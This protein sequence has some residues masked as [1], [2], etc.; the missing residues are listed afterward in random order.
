MEKEMEALK[1]MV[2][3]YNGKWLNGTEIELA[4]FGEP[5]V[6]VLV[7]QADGV[8]VVLGTHDHNYE[9]PD[10]QI[11]RRH[12]GWMIFLHPLGG[13]DASGH[14]VF[15]DDG[16]SF[17][18]KENGIGPTEPIDMVEHGEA[19]AEVDD[20]LP[21]G[22]SCVPS[23]VV[24]K[25]PVGRDED[26]QQR[27]LITGPPFPPLA[28]EHL[29]ISRKL[30]DALKAAQEALA[31]DSN[32]DEHDALWALVEILEQCKSGEYQ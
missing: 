19:I 27:G 4:D 13:S 3:T 21:T 20:I 28:I 30:I 7:H 1:L 12:N 26:C 15:L 6:P 23:M 2:P 25:A 22:P 9:K 14:V 31:G 16:R 10:I 5:S 18:S 11:E 8:R 29:P 24:E 17:I 32:D